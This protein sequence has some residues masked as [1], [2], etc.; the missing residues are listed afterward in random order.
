MFGAVR[1]SLCRLLRVPRW[2]RECV[3]QVHAVA[4]RC[5]GVWLESLELR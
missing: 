1:K 5:W 3:Q 4:G 2:K